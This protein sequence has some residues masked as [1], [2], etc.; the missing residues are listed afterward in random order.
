MAY[1][2]NCLFTIS[3]LQLTLF[4]ILGSAPLSISSC[5]TSVCPR[6]AAQ[7]KAVHSFYTNNQD[8][9]NIEKNSFYCHIV[10]KENI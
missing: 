4:L 1:T 10:L 9:K 3:S 5:I 6:S 8:K 2:C 7:C